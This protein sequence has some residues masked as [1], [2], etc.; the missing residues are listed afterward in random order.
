MQFVFLISGTHLY[1][2]PSPKEGEVSD[3]AA[4]FF[5]FSHSLS[6]RPSARA[7]LHWLALMMEV[8]RTRRILA[9]MDPH[10]LKDIGVSRGEAQT[11][12]ARAVWDIAP[13][14]W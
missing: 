2:D 8:W 10:L 3:H 13:R 6:S 4:T 1:Y 11:E 9:E 5:R 7:A 14:G 12:I